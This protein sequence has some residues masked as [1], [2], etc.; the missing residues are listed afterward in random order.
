M[1]SPLRAIL[2]W[3][4]V[5]YVARMLSELCML[6]PRH[7]IRFLNMKYDLFALS[8]PPV[9]FV[10]ILYYVFKAVNKAKTAI[11]MKKQTC[12]CRINKVMIE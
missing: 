8:R 3:K 10:G 2:F 7:T 5:V 6:E 9:P 4:R 11:I 1:L 12:Y